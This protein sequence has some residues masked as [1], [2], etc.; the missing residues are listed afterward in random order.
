MCFTVRNWWICIR[1]GGGGEEIGCVDM[2]K[3][4][5]EWLGVGPSSNLVVPDLGVKGRWWRLR[6]RVITEADGMKLMRGKP[7]RGVVGR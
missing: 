7:L 3:Y 5:K 1:I 2:E 4:G 6:N